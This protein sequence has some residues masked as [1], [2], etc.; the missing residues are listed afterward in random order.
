MVTPAFLW[1]TIANRS[2]H[3]ATLKS[4]RLVKL[5]TFWICEEMEHRAHVVSTDVEATGAVAKHCDVVR[6]GVRGTAIV[7]HSVQVLVFE[8]ADGMHVCCL[9]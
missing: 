4:L 2:V 5:E 6:N 7:P 8:V 9:P 3:V 1:K